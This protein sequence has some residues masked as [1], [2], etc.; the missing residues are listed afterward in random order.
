[1]F[2]SE[3]NIGLF[4]TTG[5]IGHGDDTWQEKKERNTVQK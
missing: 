1:M 4:F 3:C 2:L 5:K